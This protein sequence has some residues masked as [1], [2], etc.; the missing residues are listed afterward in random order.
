MST[1]SYSSLRSCLSNWHTSITSS[2]T[3]SPSSLSSTLK[4]SSLSRSSIRGIVSSNLIWCSLSLMPPLLASIYYTVLIALILS[5][6]KV[7]PSYSYCIKKGLVCVT[8]I[9]LSGRQPL[10]YAE[11]IKANICLSCNVCS[12]SDAKYIYY[13]I[14]LNCLVLYLSYYRVLDLICC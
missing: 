12:I 2:I 6:S 3:L 4:I 5:I 9:A 8:I 10:S 13:F 14:L 7:I 11:C 1:S